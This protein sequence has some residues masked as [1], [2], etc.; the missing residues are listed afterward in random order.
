MRK[1]G[2]ILALLII[3][4]S[5]TGLFLAWKEG[6]GQPESRGTPD[7]EDNTQITNPILKPPEGCFAIR[8]I[9]EGF[10]G[11][12]WTYEQRS[13]MLSFLG[14]NHFN[15]YVYAPK[16]DP[17]QR[18]RWWELYPDNDLNALGKLVAA[19]KDAGINFVYSLSPGIPQLLP[20]AKNTPDLINN[21]ITFS[22]TA[23]TDK[24]FKKI[25][26]LSLIGIHTFMLSFDDVQP[27]LK[28]ADKKKYGS[29]FARAHIDLANL[30]LTEKSKTDPAFELWF[31]PTTYYGLE[32]NAYWQ[33]I[34]KS[35]NPKIKVIWTGSW[36]LT[37]TINS[38][39]AVSVKQLLG[40]KPLIWDNYPVNDYT[41][42]TKKAPQL[43]LGPLE[44]RSA[45]LAAETEGLLANPMIQPESSKIPLMTVGAYLW[46]PKAYD[47]GNNWL[48]AVKAFTGERYD[49][50]QKFCAY[51]SAS[52]LTDYQD[53]SSFPKLA[54]AYWNEYK[55][56]RLGTKEQE[57]RQELEFLA[58]LPAR[59]NE[60]VSDPVLIAEIDPWLKKLSEEGQAGIMALDFLKLERG[61][62]LK[63]TE[64]NL[65]EQKLNS[66]KQNNLNIGSEI[67]LFI[68]DSLQYPA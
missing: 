3:A 37:K 24:L 27:V 29:N 15:T 63:R 8:G 4:G 67:I 9:V 55:Q 64:K 17:Y 26:Q 16:D 59:I 47:A 11:T 20:S 61:D 39:Q 41:Y 5:I 22:S 62:P 38:D 50:L 21:A 32:D 35:L 33:E 19:G 34:R 25:N 66:L 30:L 18:S 23:D 42:E 2:V 40:R 68:Q 43:M 48:A 65:L 31:A 10:Y 1:Y 60:T 36:V 58:G 57:L 46:D 54:A 14:K 53:H 56:K 45:D 52:V 28:D 51:S 44:N 7:V 49:F 6:V 13:D 12:P